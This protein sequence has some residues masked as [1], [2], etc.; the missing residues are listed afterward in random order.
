MSTA[1]S[2]L[3]LWV[4]GK[5]LSLLKPVWVDIQAEV[6]LIPSA[7]LVLGTDKPRL[8]GEVQKEAS[9]C[10]PG[11]E[12]RIGIKS[13]PTLFRGILTQQSM[14][15]QKGSS[16]LTLTIKH[17]LQRLTASLR[18]Q[19]FMDTKEEAIL[20]ELCS[21]QGINIKKLEGV[22]ATHPQ[23]V[24]FGCSDWKFIVTRLRANRVWLVPELDGVDGFSVT[25]PALAGQADH[26]LFNIGSKEG[27]GVEEGEWHFSCEEQPKQLAVSA[28]D[29]QAQAMSH[30]ATPASLSI[31]R[32]ALDPRKLVALNSSIWS[33]ANS[34]PLATEEQVALANA[35]WLAQQAASIHGRFTV[36]GD[37]KY[38]LG[39]TLALSG[40]GHSFDGLALITGVQHDI[41]KKHW[42]TTLQIGQSLSLDV[43]AGV[44]PKVTGVLVGV[45]DSY[46]ED[47]AKLNRLRVKVPALQDKTPLWARFAAPYASKESGLCFYPEEGD[48]VV[49]GFFADDP[50][51]PV[52]LGAM[53]NPKNLPPFPPS[54]ENNQKGLVFGQGD[55][56]HQLMFDSQKG[57]AT[58]QVSNDAMT[59][60]KGMQL[61]SDQDVTIS[62]QNLKLNAKQEVNI[63]GKKG[64]Q[65]KGAVDL[66]GSY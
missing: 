51:Y 60:H 54:T 5:Q 32:E 4:G 10:R 29:L 13:G 34:Q 56:K 52:I 63:E 7:R 8:Q 28:W 22:D 50:C 3:E 30:S 48:E 41:T 53:H 44:V 65:V 9:L 49:V 57:S 46:L 1:L 45:V 59:L 37:A 38:Q 47:P 61:V 33:L 2:K 16:E 11:S 27:V 15:L 39:Q 40:F 18:S 36:E 20:R 26:T 24:Q 58:L 35:R 42:R 43:D 12:F 64:V 25:K 6:N 55:N 23:M 66:S 62:V 31:G 21:A 14:R 19:V 17:P